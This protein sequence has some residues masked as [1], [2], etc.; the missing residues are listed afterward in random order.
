MFLEVKS[1]QWAPLNTY[2]DDAEV[3]GRRWDSLKVDGGITYKSLN[4]ILIDAGRP[5][6]TVAADDAAAM[7][8]AFAA[9][10]IKFVDLDKII[11]LLDRL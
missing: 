11:E 6:L 3:I 8:M 7:L 2:A 9:R 4:A 1:G 5:D 10:G